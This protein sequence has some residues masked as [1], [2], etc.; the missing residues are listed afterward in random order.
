MNDAITAGDKTSSYKGEVPGTFSGTEKPI[1][2]PVVATPTKIGMEIANPQAKALEEA[3]K[4]LLRDGEL[5]AKAGI[6][7]KTDAEEKTITGMVLPSE[8]L[9]EELL[10]EQKEKDELRGEIEKLQKTVNT[11]QGVQKEYD[12]LMSK[13]KS[14]PE[15]TK[16]AEIVAEPE[17]APIVENTAVVTPEPEVIQQSAPL[18]TEAT[19]QEQPPVEEK[20]AASVLRSPL[21]TATPRNWMADKPTQEQKVEEI[22]ET[23]KDNA[24]NID[25]ILADTTETKNTSDSVDAMLSDVVEP[26]EIAPVET[27]A[28]I[29]EK[30]EITSPI[31]TTPVETVAPII[32]ELK[33]VASTEETVEKVATPVQNTEQEESL[34]KNIEQLGQQEIQNLQD[35]LIKIRGNDWKKYII[36]GSAPIVETAQVSTPEKIEEEISPEKQLMKDV[37]DLDVKTFV[38]KYIK[39]EDKSFAEK[40]LK[41]TCHD[42]ITNETEVETT[43]SIFGD[44]KPKPKGV[45]VDGKGIDHRLEL[46]GVLESLSNLDKEDYSSIT[47]TVGDFIASVKTNVTKANNNTNN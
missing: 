39:S 41:A 7:L 45:T 23:P 1:N 16:A 26:V 12:E 11:L 25:T 14:A 22:T 35:T 6:I 13:M 10:N 4:K 42:I 3:K 44:H 24:Y 21:S 30:T 46:R 15:E 20:I 34:Q 28:P 5:L 43:K 32:E 37:I 8:L 27:V 31:N 2:P 36:L 19:T 40:I 9:A 47:L 18:I 38:S 33:A 29:V 17:S